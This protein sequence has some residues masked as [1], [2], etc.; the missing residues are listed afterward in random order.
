MNTRALTLDAETAAPPSQPLLPALDQGFHA[1]K[2]EELS[3]PLSILSGAPPAFRRRRT[4]FTA[5]VCPWAF[6]PLLSPA[7]TWS[8]ASTRLTPQPGGGTAPLPPRP[9]APTPTS[10]MSLDFPWGPFSLLYKAEASLHPVRM[11]EPGGPRASRA[12]LTPRP[13]RVS[14]GVR[15]PD[16]QENASGTCY[17]QVGSCCG[18]SGPTGLLP[19]IAAKD[20]GTGPATVSTPAQAPAVDLGL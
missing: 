3:P 15:A 19:G 18:D 4:A 2:V 12:P 9:W 20:S 13:P 17:G 7:V 1:V 8:T 11:Q 10:P 14:P 5:S 16:D 6:A